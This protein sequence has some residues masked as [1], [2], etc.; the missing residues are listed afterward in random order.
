MI[1]AVW[2]LGGTSNGCLT[3]T[4]TNAC[5][6]EC[7][8][9]SAGTCSDVCTTVNLTLQTTIS[10]A[11]TLFDYRSV[12]GPIQYSSETDTEDVRIGTR[13]GTTSEVRGFLSFDLGVIGSGKQIK[14]AKLSLSNPSY[15]IGSCACD[16]DPFEFGPLVIQE[17]GYGTTLDATAADFNSV[18]G[19]WNKQVATA[20]APAYDIDVVD[21]VAVS[22]SL[23]P[24]VQFRLR[25]VGALGSYGTH[26]SVPKGSAKLTVKYRVP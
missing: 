24:R 6:G 9:C 23:N 11:V 16:G 2:S 15:Y 12:G 7:D 14:S 5:N 8:K 17:S 13:P 22:Y 20:K 18:V 10:G 25:F 19:S 3:Q 26:M 1:V 4:A 21:P